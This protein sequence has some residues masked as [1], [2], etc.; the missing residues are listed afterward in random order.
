MQRLADAAFALLFESGLAS[1]GDRLT[2]RLWRELGKDL[3][4]NLARRCGPEW[5]DRLM[6][7]DIGNEL[8][9]PAAFAR[10][11][12]DMLQDK[13]QTAFGALGDAAALREASGIMMGLALHMGRG[14]GADP[15]EL[16]EHWIAAAKK[17]GAQMYADE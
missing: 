15:A 13:A 14:L 7:P 17:L 2:M 8:D 4:E 3:P 10:R 9:D 12:H 5:I 16:S 11:H 6:L 1:S